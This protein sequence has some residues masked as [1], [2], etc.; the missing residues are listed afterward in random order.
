MDAFLELVL[1]NGLL[2]LGVGLI[3][4]VGVFL[5]GKGGVVITGDHK[6]IANVVLSILVAFSAVDFSDG[7]GLVAAIA[8]VASALV[9]TLIKS[10]SAQG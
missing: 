5:L 6:R 8:S 10:F 7:A 3:V 2:G 4:L 9:Y 1:G